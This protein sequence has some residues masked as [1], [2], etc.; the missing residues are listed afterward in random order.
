MQ[1]DYLKWHSPN[2]SADFEMLTFGK[3]GYPIILFPT[4]S[5]RYYENKDFK[6]IEAASYFVEEG[7]VKIYCPDSIDAFSWYHKGI[8]P[9][10]RIKNHLW[11]EK[12]ILEELLPRARKE[13]GFQKVIVAGCSFGGYHAANIAFRHPQLVSHLWSMSGIFD[14]RRQMDGFYNDDVYFN[15]PVDFLPDDKNPELWNLKIVLGTA[16][17]DICRQD[18]ENLARIL[19][20]KGMNYWLDIRH[21]ADHDWIVWREMFPDYLSKL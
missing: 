18:N 17:R 6:L 11:Y 16:D 2:L 21:N 3:T 9:A 13:T 10:E 20:E 1:E 14:I 15:N 12:L 5:G 8:A 4:S 19:S 7:K